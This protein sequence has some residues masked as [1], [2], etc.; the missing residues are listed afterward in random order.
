[1]QSCISF[2]E[3]LEAGFPAPLPA[4][5]RESVTVQGEQWSGWKYFSGL[6]GRLPPP[7]PHPHSGGSCPGLLAY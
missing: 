4:L 5:S 1:M 3:A 2:A 7:Q 6:V